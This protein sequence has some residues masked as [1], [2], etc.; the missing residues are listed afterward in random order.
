MLEINEK[1]KKILKKW[2]ESLN[3]G[4]SS[5][6]SNEV[7]ELAYKLGFAEG[8]KSIIKNSIDFINGGF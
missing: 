5:D 8:Q 3:K 2:A 7:L 6:Y 1:D 4:E